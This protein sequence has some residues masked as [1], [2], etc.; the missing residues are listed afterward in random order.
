MI[1]IIDYGVGNLGSIQN[2]I[3]RIGSESIVTSDKEDIL[4]ASKLILPGIG[5][6]DHCMKKFN[7]TGLLSAIE[8]KIFGE[9]IPILGICVGMQMLTNGSEEGVLPGL[10]WIDAET[11]KFDFTGSEDRQLKVPHMGWNQLSE[12]G[13]NPLFKGLDEQGTKYYFVHSYYVKCAKED[14]IGACTT[15]G[16][17]FHSAIKNENLYGVQFHPEK[18]HKYGFQLF[19]NFSSM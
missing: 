5:R 2:I 9:K 16:L 17:Q 4:N 11:K 8:E 1:T 15:Y 18:S 13:D 14:N 12:F 6:F 7:E 10:G 19:R 3:K